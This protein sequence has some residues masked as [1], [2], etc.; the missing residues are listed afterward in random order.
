[1]YSAEGIKCKGCMVCMAQRVHNAWGRVC[2]VQRTWTY[3]DILY[4]LLCRSLKSGVNQ[5]HNFAEMDAGWMH[6][7]PSFH[8]LSTIILNVLGE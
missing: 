2:M 1:M 8:L 5:H 6:L 7:G 3:H 4:I